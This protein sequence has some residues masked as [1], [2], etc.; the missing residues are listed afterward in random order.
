MGPQD[1]GGQRAGHGWESAALL[2]LP[3]KG[4][5]PFLHMGAL[6]ALTA[7]SWIVAGQFARAER[8]CK[9]DWAGPVPRRYPPSTRPACPAL[10]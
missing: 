10:T 6:A 8:S 1:A 4:T 9:Y 2:P 5:A 3:H 7:L